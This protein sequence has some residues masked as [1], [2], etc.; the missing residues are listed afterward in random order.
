V[1]PFLAAKEC[2]EIG[3]AFILAK[4]EKKHIPTH[5]HTISKTFY[6]KLGLA[7]GKKFHR[8]AGVSYSGKRFEGASPT[9]T[10]TPVNSLEEKF[11]DIFL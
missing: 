3:N 8:D 10:P 1:F 4:R 2:F 7:S 6:I 5:T 9:N 11:I